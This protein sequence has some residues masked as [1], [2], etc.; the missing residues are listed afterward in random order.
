LLVDDLD[1]PAEVEAD[2]GEADG[3]QEHPYDE[4]EAPCH[5][6]IP[7][8]GAVVRPESV[9]GG[10]YGRV[11]GRERTSQRSMPIIIPLLDDPAGASVDER[12][13]HLMLLEAARHSLDVEWTQTLAA[14]EAAGDHDTMGYPSMVAYLKHRFR[15]AGGRAH[16]YVKDARAALMFT[17]T[18]SAWKHR[19]ISS[20]EAE[21]LFRAAERTPD[22]YPEAERQLLELT[23]DGVDE[24]RRVLDYWSA[25][26]DLPGI[27]LGIEEQLARRHFDVTRKDNGMVAGEFA[28]PQLEG[29]TFLA[30]IETLMPPP[31]KGDVRSTTQRRADALGDL[32]RSFL[33]GSE[34]PIVGGGRPH[35]NVHVDIAALEG[36]GGGLHE[37]EDGV[38][39]DNETVRQLACDSSVSRIVFGPNSEILDV[40][41][42][43]RVIPAAL[44]RAVIARDRHCVAPGC[45][46]S[47]RWSDVHHIEPWGDGG[48]TVI[49]NL[50]L[51]CRYHH[52]LVHL[53]KL[54]VSDLEI[55]QP[56]GARSTQ[57][58]RG[59]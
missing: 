52:T 24:T 23:G 37:T 3:D 33:E 2:A 58:R 39:L 1:D 56:L 48:E 59:P 27:R 45:G 21:L 55:R 20:D 13:E 26:V 34:T 49:E 6:S 57:G 30:A 9:G 38:V 31:V 42:K 47:A 8:E 19:Q 15:M 7:A 44:R 29:E 22:R 17:S 12:D 25:R 14:A 18:F 28:L 32:A 40:G 10:L 51:L 11:M 5:M 36:I 50:C 16:R 43:T 46:R 54:D 35:L 41:R 4:G 53:G